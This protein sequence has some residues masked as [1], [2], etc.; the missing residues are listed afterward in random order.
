[1]TNQTVVKAILVLAVYGTALACGMLLYER[2][3]YSNVNKITVSKLAD[4]EEA[5][6]VGPSSLR[7]RNP[8]F[9][10]V[11][12]TG[13]YVHAL[14]DAKQWF[15]A[16][17]TEFMP[18]LEAAGGPAD[19][20]N[21][22]G[23]A[24]IVLLSHTSALILQLDWRTQF[25]AA[26]LGCA[27]TDAGAIK[28][29]RYSTNSSTEFYLPNA[30]LKSRRGPGQPRATSCAESLGRFVESIDDLLA[31]NVLDDDVFWAMIRKYLPTTGCRFDEVISISGTSK[32]FMRRPGRYASYKISFRNVDTIVSFTIEKDTG[33]ISYPDISSTHLPSL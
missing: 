12:F 13:D 20:Y 19:V 32:F 30:T 33:D 26:N 17:D 31:E 5:F 14:K 4:M 6:E 7:V 24:S 18:A 8:E 3:R 15:A 23:Q 9:L 10:K 29:K 2:D 28:I 11:C 21:G 25:F 22:E 16:D 1:L 27:S